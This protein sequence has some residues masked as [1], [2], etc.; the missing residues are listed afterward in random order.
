M[1]AKDFQSNHRGGLLS[2]HYGGSPYKAFHEAGLVTE[3]DEAYMSHKRRK[4]GDNE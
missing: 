3:K 1:T 2:S 4:R